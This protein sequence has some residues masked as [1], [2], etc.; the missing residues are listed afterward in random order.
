MKLF[1]KRVNKRNIRIILT[2]VIG[3]LF[4][5]VFV[6]YIS[7]RRDMEEIALSIEKVEMKENVFDNYSFSV[8]RREKHSWESQW[9]SYAKSKRCFLSGYNTMEEEFRFYRNELKKRPN[10]FSELERRYEAKTPVEFQI[11]VWKV[12]VKRGKVTE[13][14]CKAKK[15]TTAGNVIVKFK[16]NELKEVF[17]YFDDLTFYYFGGDG[18]KTDIRLSKSERNL[19][20]LESA[21]RRCHHGV[22]E[23][24]G[25]NNLR[26][27]KLEE[28]RNWKQPFPFFSPSK[29]I[30]CHGDLMAPS[31]EFDILRPPCGI[32]V[33]WR[34][35]KSA[36]YWR[37]SDTGTVPVLLL[38]NVNS[39]MISTLVNVHNI[40]YLLHADR[41]FRR[42]ADIANRRSC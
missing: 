4:C 2:V 33:P 31:I 30:G 19:S 42:E 26:R 28:T 34:K 36:I 25:E 1:L 6:A 5:R 8:E 35:K 37:G 32:T 14:G 21:K 7:I 3:T 9:L 15:C 18:T 10:L 24:L 20:D 23:T 11:E 39:A 22:A 12:V 27:L 13:I 40:T 38:F 29:I 17:W 16:I 41:G